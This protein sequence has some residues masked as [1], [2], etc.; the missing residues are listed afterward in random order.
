MLTAHRAAPVDA[1]TPTTYDTLEA[2]EA[3]CVPMTAIVPF[4]VAYSAGVVRLMMVLLEG[5]PAAAPCGRRSTTRIFH[6][7]A[8]VL[9]FTAC[10]DPPQSTMNAVPFMTEIVVLTSLL[11]LRDQATVRRL[12]LLGPMACLLKWNQ[13]WQQQQRQQWRQS[14]QHWQMHALLDAERGTG[15]ENC[16]GVIETWT[17]KHLPYMSA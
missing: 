3:P 8:P 10:I 4:S 1:F 6:F 13:Q 14:Q 16:V 15:K 5:T 11:V 17:I 9:A 7:V 2:T 12:T